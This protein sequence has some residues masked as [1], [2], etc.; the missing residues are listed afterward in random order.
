MVSRVS[1]KPLTHSER[2]RLGNIKR[3][4]S[5]QPRSVRLDDLSTEQ[6]RL[7]VALVEAAKAAKADGDG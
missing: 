2:G 5:D 6:R 7:V 4:G 3:W 1:D